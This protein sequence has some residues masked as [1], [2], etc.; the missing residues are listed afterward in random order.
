MT[1]AD[2]PDDR[3]GGQAMMRLARK[4]SLLVALS[5]LTSAATAYA[6]CAWVLWSETTTGWT[7]DPSITPSAVTKTQRECEIIRRRT[8]TNLASQ[9][10]N[11]TF[12]AE[13]G[14]VATWRETPP[15][16]FSGEEP[17]MVQSFSCFPDTVDQRGPKVS[18]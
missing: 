14:F 8:V 3:Q 16:P 15:P 13:A 5:L 2:V 4:A 10:R 9:R 6:E 1:E 11:S 17:T 7:G 12:N 18:K